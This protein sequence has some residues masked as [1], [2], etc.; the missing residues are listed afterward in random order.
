MEI[1]AGRNFRD[2]A[3]FS[4]FAKIFAREIELHKTYRNIDLKWPKMASNKRISPKLNAIAHVSTRKISEKRMLIFTLNKV[5]QEIRI[6]RPLRISMHSNPQDSG[7]HRNQRWKQWKQ[8]GHDSFVSC[9]PEMLSMSKQKTT[10]FVSC[11]PGMLSMS[12]Q[13]T[14]QL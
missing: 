13:K 14:S 5:Y 7:I 9:P 10:I 4:A 11:P 2:F 8:C 12:K 6:C 1:F 3:K